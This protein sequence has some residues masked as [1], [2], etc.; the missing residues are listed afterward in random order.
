MAAVSW[1][2]ALIKLLKPDQ[3]STGESVLYQH[4]KGESF[5]KAVL[6]DVVL[7]PESTLDVQSIVR[8]AY[9]GGIPITPV[10][11]NSSLEGHTVP[12]HAGISLDMTRMN[13]ILEFKPEDLLI[14]VQPAVTYPQINDY[15]KRSGR[16]F[17]H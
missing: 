1:L 10:A 3:V 8:F 13:K 9:D 15:T 5:D 17:S 11:V 7:F 6:P 12:L 4:S 16:F 14:V 2:E